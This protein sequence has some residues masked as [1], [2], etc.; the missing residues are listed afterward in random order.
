VINLRVGLTRSSVTRG[1]A[2]SRRTAS[3]NGKT[4]SLAG[5]PASVSAAADDFHFKRNRIP[6]HLTPDTAIWSVMDDLAG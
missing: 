3:D 4:K 6:F 1:R 2:A 5:V